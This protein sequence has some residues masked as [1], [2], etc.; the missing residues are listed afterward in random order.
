MLLRLLL[1]TVLLLGLTACDAN[2]EKFEEGKHYEVVSATGSETPKVQ[3]FFS[4]YCGH[5]Y[6]FAPV[7]RNLAANIPADIPFEKVHVDFMAAAPA[8]M[9]QALSRAY[10]VGKEL[11]QADMVAGLIFNYIHQ[12]GAGF[13]SDS[14]IRNLLLVNDI[15][16]AAF[17]AKF[18]S[19]PILSAVQSM[20]EQQIKWSENGVLKGVPTL[21]VNG[22]YKVN[23]A[24]LEPE[25][26]EADLQALV[27]FLLTK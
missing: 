10:L 8:E 20:K 16:A 15:D 6:R 7:A 25:Q 21:I 12:Q 14:D 5:C 18:N 3:E 27:N 4:F 24:A 23:Y 2:A 13:N 22:R 11:G 1:S 19:L 26:F 9:Q 17:D